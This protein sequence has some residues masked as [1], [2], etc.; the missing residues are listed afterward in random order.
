MKLKLPFFNRKNYIV[1]KAYNENSNLV[2]HAPLIRSSELPPLPFFY[3]KTDEPKKVFNDRL[4]FRTC[5]GNVASLK[6]SL[7]VPSWQHFKISV[8][9]KL[10]IQVMQSDHEQ[11]LGRVE[12][13]HNEDPYYDTTNFYVVKMINR[14]F[15]EETTGVNFVYAQHIRNN[16]NMR[17]VSGLINFRDQHCVNIFN[18]VSKY[19]H[20]YDIPFNMPIVAL[21]PMSDKPVHVECYVDKQKADQLAIASTTRFWPVGTH[22]KLYNKK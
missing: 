14:W 21:Y 7:T 8:G 13:G 20:N 15:L 1:V 11:L 22:L 5:Y 2:R 9:D 19:P 17:A 4:T 12:F 16:T 10:N 18:L 6:R 3:D